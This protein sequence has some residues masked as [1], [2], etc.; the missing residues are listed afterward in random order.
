MR[1]TDRLI[2]LCLIMGLAAHPA[3]GE[4]LRDLF[5]GEALYHADQGQ[6]FEAIQRL[7]TELAQYH[8]LDQ[9]ELDTLHYHANEAEF[10]VGDFELDYRMHYRAGRAIKRVLEGSVDDAVRNEAAFRLARIHFQKDQLD[11]ALEALGRIRGPVPEQIKDDVE[12]LRANIYMATNRPGEAVEVLGHLQ[13]DKSLSGF[14]SYNLGIALLQ[15]GRQKEAID[16]L[17]KAGQL[18]ADDP[19]ALAIRDKSN[20]V[21]GALLF[22][23]GNFER[24]KQTLDRVRLEGPFSNQALLRAGWA[25]ASTQHYDRA[26]VPWNILANREPTD[27]AVQ[28]AMLTVPHAYASLK[29]YGRSA[30]MYGRALELFSNQI[31]KVDA[32]IDSV[33]DGRFLKALIREESREDQS[34]VIR[35]RTLP[36]APETYY[37]ME[38]M[39][40]HDFQTAMHNYL[41]LEDLRSKLVTWQTGLDAFDDIIRLRKQ[42][43]EPLLPVV[44]AQFQDLDSRM[45]LRLEQ[46]K[47]LAER[48]QTMLTAPRPDYLATADERAT[49]ERIARIEK[50]LEHSDSAESLALRQ[51]AARLQGVLTWRLETEYQNRLTTAYEHLNELNTQIDALTRQYQAFVRT[52]QAAKHSYVGYDAQI[53]EL[54][55]RA[56]RALERVDT[57]MARQGHMIETVAINQLQARRE[58]LVAQQ[59][60]AR[61]GVADSYDRTARLQSGAEGH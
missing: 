59:T 15:A 47:H 31:K 20:L 52:R 58:R 4:D 49:G 36:G 61:Y 60:Q 9:P 41:D 18:A 29:L 50:Q 32:S 35:L 22:E 37:L 5:F 1:A 11:D 54:R 39:A 14:A 56:R 46:H 44:D 12:F 7:D 13:N 48:L 16:Q 26:L 55:E 10:S 38:L 23:S 25:E 34:W 45:R 24:A 21:L 6:Y 19:A 51:R 8:R 43:F 2:G 40:S 28:E 27:V 42:N 33:N 3:S 30:L 53:A 57:L 17:D